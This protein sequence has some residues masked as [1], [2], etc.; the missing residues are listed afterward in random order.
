M[1]APGSTLSPLS[2]R[3]FLTLWLASLAAYFGNAIQSVGAAWLMTALDGRADRV[4]LV[5]TAIQLPIM[6]FALVGGAVADLYDRRRVMLAAQTGIALASAALALLAWGRLVTPWLLLSLTFALGIG[7]AF[8]NPAAQASLGATVPRPE[9]AGAAS[10]HILGFNV[11]RTLGPAIGGA[12]VAFGGGV[13]A[14]VCNAIFCLVAALT[15]AL[16]RLPARAAA[17][18]RQHVHRAIAEGLRCVRDLPPLRAIVARGLAFTLAGSAIWALMPLVARDLTGG[19]AQAFGLLLAALGLGAVL[20]AAVSHEVRRRFRHETILRA[21]SLVF[22]AACL[23]VAAR[24]GFAP[25][26]AVL[27]AGGAFWVQALSGFSVAAQLHAP[28][29]AVGRVTAT[30]TTVVYGGMALGAWLWGH[31]AAWTSLATAIAG[32]GAAMVLVAGLGL[33][34]PM[35]EADDKYPA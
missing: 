3:L 21:A 12:L 6:L 14:F 7:T 17:P 25:S 24:P 32:S 29:H 2:H 5:Q 15:L 31:V 19:G 20:G 35:P 23:I 28:G 33:I 9:L 4:A 30:S 22:G 26:F 34:L 13:A 11:A 27:V 8:Y 10:L 18:A 1:R 16:W